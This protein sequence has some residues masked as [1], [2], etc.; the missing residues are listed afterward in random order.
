MSDVKPATQ[1][2]V[3]TGSVATNQAEFV[4]LRFTNTQLITKPYQDPIL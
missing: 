1:V 2:N 3:G 4:N